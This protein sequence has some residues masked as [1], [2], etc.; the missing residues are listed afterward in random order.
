MT[1]GL[2]K[3]LAEGLPVRVR[4][5]AMAADV[6][7]NSVYGAVRR[8]EIE[9]VR[10]G[11]SIRIP[12]REARASW[13][14]TRNPRGDEP[15]FHITEMRRRPASAGACAFRRC[16]ARTPRART[17][18]GLTAAPKGRPIAWDDDL[19]ARPEHEK[20][21]AVT[22][23]SGLIE[24]RRD[25]VTSPNQL[26]KTSLPGDASCLARDLSYMPESPLINKPLSL[27]VPK[28]GSA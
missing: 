2:Q 22:N 6:S 16:A 8:G 28:I 15:R 26:P 21:G 7:P 4:P 20:A 25:E 12:A 14:S 13:A 17:E 24:E 9:S 23:R 1:S 3:T 11:G 10:I 5:F 19:R 27:P 18:G